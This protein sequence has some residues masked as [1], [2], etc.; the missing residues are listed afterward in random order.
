MLLF[1]LLFWL[2]L[3]CRFHCH[4]HCRC[5]ATIALVAALVLA[6][7]LALT[8]VF[9]FILELQKTC[10]FGVCDCARSLWLNSILQKHN[11]FLASE[12]NKVIARKREANETNYWI[13]LNILT[14]LWHFSFKTWSDLH[15]TKSILSCDW[16]HSLIW[17]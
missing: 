3:C 16:K 11:Y 10:Y 5:A 15:G 17:P 12:S 1:F 13:N 14:A 2:F 4:S 7:I 9:D 8:S 6:F